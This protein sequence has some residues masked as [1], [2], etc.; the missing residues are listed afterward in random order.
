MA[1]LYRELNHDF[2]KSWSSDMGY[3]LGYFAADGTMIKSRRG[4]HF[5]EFDSIDKVLIQQ[6]RAAMKSSHHIGV[7]R[8]D[9]KNKNWKTAYRL[10]VGSIKMFNDLQKL[11]FTQK[12][13]L[14]IKFPTIP[15]KYFSD[16]V[17]GYFDGDGNV[18]FKKHYAKDRK[19]K[20]WVFS[21]RFTSGCK[22]FLIDLHSSL[23]KHGIK[24]GFI[25][26]NKERRGF[27]LV[28]SHLDSLALHKLMYNTAPDTS[29]Y[30]PR[31][32]K[33]FRKALKTMY[34]EM[35]A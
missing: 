4:G 10:Q 18:Y 13:S 11:G 26:S 9:L 14:T 20:R 24:G 22:Q 27:N 1:P 2:F 28:M 30:L 15:D 6:V 12:K 21:S 16:F 7:R 8:R 17:R 25:L 3:V 33:L 35:R 34:P 29:L 19:Q 32:Y 23:G 31:K 5:I